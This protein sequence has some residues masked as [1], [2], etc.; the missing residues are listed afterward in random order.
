VTPVNEKSATGLPGGGRLVDPPMFAIA[1][2]RIGNSAWAVMGSLAPKN[3]LMS[4]VSSEKSQVM[5]ATLVPPSC[6][7]SGY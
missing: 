7:P 4:G 1:P 6:V 2:V 5:V 3:E